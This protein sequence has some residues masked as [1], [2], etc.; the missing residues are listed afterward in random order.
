MVRKLVLSAIA[1]LAV[2]GSASAADLP[3]YKAVPAPAFTWDGTY[4]GGTV[5]YGWGDSF[6]FQGAA[7]TLPFDIDGMVA[8]VTLG[9]NWQRGAFVFGIETD[10]SYSDISGT[11]PSNNGF[12]CGGL[13]ATSLE[14]FGTFRGRI[15]LANGPFLPYITGGLA[16]GRIKAS[17][18]DGAS[19]GSNTEIGWV[20]GAGLEYA[21]GRNW[22]AKVE[23]LRVDLG[24]T[25]NYDTALLCGGTGCSAAY[26]AFDIV[27]LG[28]NYRW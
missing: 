20:V 2:A 14:W 3:V 21:L 4:I 1:A 19:R 15:G 7:N 5:G 28:V 24:D 22:S 12:G 9:K 26:S 23:Y 18:A 10:I 16:Y 25:I 6:H 17:I 11:S 27:R 13:C 8:G